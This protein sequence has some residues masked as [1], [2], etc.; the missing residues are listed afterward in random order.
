MKKI[1]TITV[2]TLFLLALFAVNRT[3]KAEEKSNAAQ[4]L[5]T[6]VDEYSKRLYVYADYSDSKNAFTQRGFMGG[7][8]AEEPTLDEASQ[9]AYSGITST[10]VTAPIRNGGWS[11]LVFANGILEKGSIIPQMDWGDHDAGINLTG[12]K[13]LVIHA[14]AADSETAIVEFKMGVIGGA[15]PDTD[16]KSSGLVNLTDE[17]STI[18]IDLRG[19]DLSRITGG[20]AILFNDENKSNSVTVYID[21]VY[22]EF[23]TPRTDPLFLPSYEPVS[24]NKAGSFINSFSYSYDMAMAVL[25][26]AYAD[27]T[28]QAKKIADALLFAFENDRKFSV[29]ERGV[30]NGYASGSPVSF[31]GW[32]SETGKAPFAKL[33]GTF[34]LK[35]NIWKEDFYSD[36][37]ATG[38]NA[39]ILLAFLKMYDATHEHKYWNAALQL[40]AY[41]LTLKDD[42]NGGFKGGWDGFDN[43]QTKAMY[44]STEH[45]IDLYSAFRQLGNIVKRTD[46]AVAETYYAAAE[47]AKNFVFSM[48]HAEEGVFYTGTTNDGASTNKTIYPLDVNTWA[49]QSFYNEPGFDAE[50]VMSYIENNFRD[51]ASGFYKFSDKTPTGYWTEGSYQK[52]ISDL[53]LGHTDTYQA[54]L[55]QL[56]AEAKPDGSITATN[57]DGLKTGFYIGDGS[58]W[59]YDHRVSVGATAWKALAELGV[60]VLDPNLYLNDDVGNSFEAEISP[61]VYIENGI[62]HVKEAPEGEI[63]Q[64]YSITGKL[65]HQATSSAGSADYPISSSDERVLVVKGSSGWVKKVIQ[66]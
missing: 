65:L 2:S 40:A 34:D 30:R 11:G 39:W 48:I 17:W 60:N 21:E 47:H 64:V 51:P 58:E 4:W 25:A 56:N 9:V 18:E 16:E 23:D 1:K 38:N 13:K 27:K 15:Y 32:Y 45:N 24:L 50:K 22:Y 31:P 28:K 3:G 46:E 41:L 57:I 62:L 26:L 43:A 36:S 59:I 14:R 19:A 61:I 66:H 37:Y 7:G 10:R 20:F 5:A 42:V 6:Q 33:A 52:I 44:A 8:G 49:I 53:V 54:Q 12:A 35:G 63:I 29:T 55:A